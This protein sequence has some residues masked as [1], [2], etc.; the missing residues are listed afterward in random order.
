MSY[1]S[2]T[3]EDL[4]EG[5]VYVLHGYY[6]NPPAPVLIKYLGIKLFALCFVF[7]EDSFVAPNHEYTGNGMEWIP[8][9]D[10]GEFHY[11]RHYA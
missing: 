4:I 11:I 1:A 5:H 2:L 6:S 9:E 3:E 10:L 8:R 7:T